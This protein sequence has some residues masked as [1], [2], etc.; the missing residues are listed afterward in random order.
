MAVAAGAIPAVT[1]NIGPHF[2]T[3]AAADDEDISFAGR[4]EL[5]GKRQAR[6]RQARRAVDATRAQ[7]RE[8]LADLYYQVRAAFVDLQAATADEQIARQNVDLA[9]TLLTLAQAQLEVG[10]VPQTNVIRAE[11]ELENAQ[12]ELTAAAATTTARRVTLNTVIGADPGAPL[13]VPPLALPAQTAADLDALR[14]LALQRPAIRAAEATLAQREA[15]VD[16]ARLAR[17]PDLTGV[18]NHEHLTEYPGNVLRLGLEFPLFD[19]GLTRANTHAAQAAVGEQS[20]N[21]RLLRL[22]AVQ[23]VEVAYRNLQAAI[24]QAE[25]LGGPQLERARHLVELAQLGYREGQ[26]SQLE[27]L[28]AQRA[29]LQTFTL[30]QHA[31]AA[32]NTA[33]AALDRAIGAVGPAEGR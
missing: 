16:V 24:Q 19:F 30:Y 20:A 15:A 31:L 26:F 33:A 12:Q 27:L 21:V 14:E 11:I 6:I 32:A 9:Q 10:A 8:A 18:A 29:F 17:R 3:G 13:E 5:G 28:D 4:L 2:G 1:L 7:E 25:R 22:Q 23:D